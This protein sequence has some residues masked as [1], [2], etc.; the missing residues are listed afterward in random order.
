MTKELNVKSESISAPLSTQ[1]IGLFSFFL[2]SLVILPAFFHTQPITGPLVN[3][4]LLMT[5]IVFNFETALLLS[6][7]PSSIAVVSG[8]LPMPLSPM[9]PF[10]I[11]GNIIYIFFFD[12]LQQKNI[13]LAVITASL[14]KFILLASVVKTIMPL[15]I[16][17]QLIDQLTMMM[18]W[19]QLITALIGGLIAIGLSKIIKFK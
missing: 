9:I 5:I 19:P 17:N 15:L 6:F 7:I 18:T 10:I 12:R 1:N 11:T 3:A 4:A 8:I 16:Q 2:I 14:A 13:F